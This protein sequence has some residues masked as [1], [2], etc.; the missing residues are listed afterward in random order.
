VV[1]ALRGFTQGYDT[2]TVTNEQHVVIAAEVMT[3][4]P[5]FGHLEP[6]PDLVRR[7]GWRAAA[8]DPGGQLVRWSHRARDGARYEGS[9]VSALSRAAAR[10]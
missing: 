7:T 6:M 8:S 5:N 9:S 3:A 2:Q 4:A 10:C 1:K